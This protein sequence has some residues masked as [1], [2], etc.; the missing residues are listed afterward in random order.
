MLSC[1]APSSTRFGQEDNIIQQS[2][3]SSTAF[4]MQCKFP[5][6]TQRNGSIDPSSGSLDSPGSDSSLT[7]LTNCLEIHFA[8]SARC[9]WAQ[10][11]CVSVCVS[12]CLS[13]YCLLL[14]VFHSTFAKRA[15][16]LTRF[17]WIAAILPTRS[18]IAVWSPPL[19]G[20]QI[21]HSN[22]KFTLNHKTT[23][24]KYR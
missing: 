21:R 11:A 6:A 15:K 16:S 9:N 24:Q 18:S 17:R 8:L 12:V 4:S 20:A 10:W 23:Q 7:K 2:M 14:A 19:T 3:P 5:N 22:T 1:L 13:V